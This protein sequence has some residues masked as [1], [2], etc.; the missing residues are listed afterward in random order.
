[1]WK[2][3]EP[4]VKVEE[5]GFLSIFNLGGEDVEVQVVVDTDETTLKEG[6]KPWWKI[7]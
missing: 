5:G 3:P 7:F 2:E 6:K 1:M 4:E